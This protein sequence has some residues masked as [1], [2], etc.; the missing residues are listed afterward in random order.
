MSNKEKAFIF[1]MLALILI[2]TASINTN[3]D[4]ISHLI[5]DIFVFAAIIYAAMLLEKKY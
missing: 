2:N 3:L 5:Q 1:L 4:N